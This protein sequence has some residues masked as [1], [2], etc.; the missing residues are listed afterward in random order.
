M[1]PEE[2]NLFYF[3]SLVQLVLFLEHNK[4]RIIHNNTTG[5]AV[6]QIKKSMKLL[7]DTPYLILNIILSQG[8]FDFEFF[9][10]SCHETVVY[11]I[12]YNLSLRTR[13]NEKEAPPK[14]PG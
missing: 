5:P 6:P 9:T 12:K 2:R 8:M 14:K 4:I 11:L 1:T 7:N 13:E 3:N 10:T